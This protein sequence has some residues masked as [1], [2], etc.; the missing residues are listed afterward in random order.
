MLMTELFL[1]SAARHGH[2]VAIDVPPGPGRPSRRTVT[3][4]ELADRAER[5]A[6]RLRAH[7]HGEA[8]VVVLLPREDPWLFAAQLATLLVG[9]AHVCLDRSFP[10][11]HLAHVVR[12]ARAVAV[13]TDPAGAQRFAGLGA[14]VLVADDS[15]A[16]QAA[17]P[18]AS[19]GP[20]AGPT[21]AAP[22]PPWLSAASLAYCI[23]TSGTSGAPKAVLI[24]HRGVVNLIREGV[25]RFGIGPEDR[26]AQ[27][28]SP[29]YDSSVEE[30]WLALAAGATLVVLDDDAVRLGPDLVPWLRRERVTV[31]CPP[32]TLLRAMA[33]A[34]PRERLPALRLCYVGGEPLPDDLAASWGRDLWL[35]NG[36]GPTECTVTVVRGR[37]VPGEPVTI[38]T[39]VPPHTSWVLDESMQPVAD[40]TPGELCIAGPG[41]ARGYLGLDE[42]TAARFPTL[43]GIGRVYRT[44][45]LVVRDPDG[46]LRCLGRI[47]AQV[48]LRGYR[49]ELEAVEA[50]L[51]RCD[52]VREAVCTV[53]GDEPGR[54]LVAHV[55]PR[56]RASPPRAD[57]L[58]EAVR[59][60]LP[61]YM[62]PAAIALLDRVPRT[63]GG[64]VDR[65]ALPRLGATDGTTDGA[66]DR[67]SVV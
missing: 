26:V 3:Y 4:A 16:E 32:P 20:T 57:G 38:G 50:A 33:C 47:D 18:A 29:A 15:R 27:G 39:P 35:E 13:I 59:A 62:I 65:R 2:R 55:V 14:P 42:L 58:R 7:V 1:A 61:P 5:L 21:A 46:R 51:L 49:I 24:E 66:G 34:S 41:L 10:D 8:V 63:I 31:L 43:P 64:K 52:G 48:K 44:G 25:A 9:A 40:G 67:K 56:D 22:P 19:A 23:Y 53:E 17:S 37:V 11:G 12:D 6:S 45:D 28:S 36:Y 30:T 54:A 60:Q